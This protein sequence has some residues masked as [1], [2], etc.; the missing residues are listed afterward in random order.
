MNRTEH[1]DFQLTDDMERFVG[2]LVVCGEASK[3]H[4]DLHRENMSKAY[5]SVVQGPNG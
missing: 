5:T 2:G 1:S 4:P 3:V